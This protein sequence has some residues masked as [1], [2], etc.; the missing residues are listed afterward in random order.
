MTYI[1]IVVTILPFWIIIFAFLGL[2][3]SKVHENR[4]SEFG[5]LI[6]GSLIGILLVISYGYLANVAIFPARLVTVY[7]F[8]L[9]F[10]FVILF[11]TIARGIRRDLFTYGIGINYV[12]IVGDTRLTHELV[13]S[14]ANTAKTGYRVAGI[15]GGDKHP[16][17][18]SLGHRVFP[19]FEE[20]LH[21]IHPRP[22]AI[23]QTE[24][25]A[26]AAKNDE[27]LEYAQTHHIDYRFV[28]GNSEL[29]VGNIDVELFQSIPVIAVNQTALIG[30]GRVVK[31]VTDVVLSFLAIL[32]TSPFWL[33]T[34]LL[35]LLSRNGSVFFRQTRL[36]RHNKEF[37]VYKFRSQYA[38]FDGTTPE[39]AF[40]MLGKPELAEKYRANGDYLDH[41]PRVTPIGHFIRRASID[42]L[43]QLLNVLKGDI[44]LVGPRALIPQELAV[45]K[46]RH[47][48]LSVK[49][50]LTGL[51]QVSGRRNISFDERRK[52]D[53]Y[54]VQNW[55]FWNDVIIMIRT[56]W[57][58]LFHKGSN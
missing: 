37:K 45:Y 10:I 57:I 32:I 41:D 6:V 3:N 25:Y 54:Y 39:E 26:A 11:R 8:L 29:F 1:S 17:D 21:K 14:L 33:L 16:L 56:V 47:A 53:L 4:F 40:T 9:A 55:S 36:T 23:I 19:S 15:V 2:Y 7:G 30:W 46:K 27:I 52:L 13:N 35:L 44:S 42:E 50:G 34:A 5:R 24:L 28:P 48:I 31:R 20:A 12:L 43:P 51:A 18:M 58:V 49:S 38:R 22:H